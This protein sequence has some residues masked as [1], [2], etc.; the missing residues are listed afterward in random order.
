MNFHTAQ[1]LTQL[2]ISSHS[3]ATRVVMIINFVYFNFSKVYNDALKN[4]LF[5]FQLDLNPSV[6]WKES[7]ACFPGK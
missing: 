4:H 7:V 3:K 6:S 2:R 1:N 5:L